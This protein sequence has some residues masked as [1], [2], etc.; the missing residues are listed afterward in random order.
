MM[1]ISV[2]KRGRILCKSRFAAEKGILLT[3]NGTFWFKTFALR[4]INIKKDFR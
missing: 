4:D 2:T 1:T 3:G